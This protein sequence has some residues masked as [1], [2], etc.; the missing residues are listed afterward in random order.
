[1]TVDASSISYRATQG[2]VAAV[3][4][5]DHK[6]PLKGART[7]FSKDEG[8]AAQVPF[9]R[10]CDGIDRALRRVE[11]PG[12]LGAFQQKFEEAQQ[13]LHGPH[14]CSGP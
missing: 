7:R 11:I 4:E 8:R 6:L 12:R 14:R 13:G 3:A 5:R 9:D 1:L 2:H 10:L